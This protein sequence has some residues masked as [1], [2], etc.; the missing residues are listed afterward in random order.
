MLF[1]TP[2]PEQLGLFSRDHNPA[3]IEPPPRLTTQPPPPP[4]T[5]WREK[6]QRYESRPWGKDTAADRRIA[7]QYKDDGTEAML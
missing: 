5:S 6:W 4:P 2:P 1:G 7:R 3:P